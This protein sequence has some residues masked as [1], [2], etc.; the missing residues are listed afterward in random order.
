[1]RTTS[2]VSR[3]GGAADTV[4]L[5]PKVE[6]R[7]WVPSATVVT[8]PCDGAHVSTHLAVS[9][10]CAAPKTKHPGSDSFQI[11]GL[12]DEKL[13]MLTLSLPMA[14]TLLPVSPRR[15]AKGI[16]PGLAGRQRQDHVSD[17]AEA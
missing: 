9:D 6:L 11:R 10:Q 15:T 16:R 7:G 14:S 1:V 4:N 17:A 13:L 12:R 2:G 5:V 3:D 8:L